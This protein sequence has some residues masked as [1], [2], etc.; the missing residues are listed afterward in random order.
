MR[1]RA[2]FVSAPERVREA[3]S[4][5]PADTVGPAEEEEHECA[6]RIP[7]HYATWDALLEEGSIVP[8][9]SHSF[10]QAFHSIASLLCCQPTPQLGGGGVEGELASV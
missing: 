4:I 5:A 9:L 1:T 10:I 3:Y 7:F 6:A 8:R 2:G